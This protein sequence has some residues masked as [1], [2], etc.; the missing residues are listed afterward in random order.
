MAEK[1]GNCAMSVDEYIQQQRACWWLY[2]KCRAQLWETTQYTA[3]DVG[4]ILIRSGVSPG[5]S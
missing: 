2:L 1:E 5:V 3:D 4:T